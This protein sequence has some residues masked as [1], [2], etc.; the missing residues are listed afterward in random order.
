VTCNTIAGNVEEGRYFIISREQ[1]LTNQG[2]TSKV[3]LADAK[4]DELANYAF[5]PS[6]GALPIVTT[7]GVTGGSKFS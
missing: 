1:I 4:Y 6:H 3:D 2:K 7:M 5:S